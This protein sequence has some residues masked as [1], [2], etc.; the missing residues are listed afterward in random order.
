MPQDC[1]RDCAKVKNDNGTE[2]Y[3]GNLGECKA[4]PLS[5]RKKYLASAVG[6][7][8]RRRLRNV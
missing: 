6:F 2:I 1:G 4:E 3:L 8:L 7:N 5:D